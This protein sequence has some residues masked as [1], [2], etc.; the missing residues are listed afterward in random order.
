M[1]PILS[2]NNNK[3][4]SKY[5]SS[6]KKCLEDKKKAKPLQNLMEYYEFVQKL[7]KLTS[8]PNKFSIKKSKMH[9]TMP[10]WAADKTG[11]Y[12]YNKLSSGET[13]KLKLGIAL[14]KE[15]SNYNLA[16]Y[17][18]DD[19]N[20]IV[21]AKDSNGSYYVVLDHEMTI[22]AEFGLFR[23]FNK[24]SDP[25]AQGVNT[26]FATV[27]PL[28]IK[29]AQAI[30]KNKSW[31]QPT[32]KFK[33]GFMEKS[34]IV[35]GDS[36]K[37]DINPVDANNYDSSKLNLSIYLSYVRINADNT[38]SG[39]GYGIGIVK[40][41]FVREIVN[42]PV[43]PNSSE[44][45]ALKPTVVFLETDIDNVS[46]DFY[47]VYQVSYLGNDKNMQ[48][49]SNTEDGKVVFEDRLSLFFDPTPS[50]FGVF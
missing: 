29:I 17:Q 34:V 24:T 21:R 46:S 48:M 7:Q 26:V 25:K 5:I 23:E 2:K 38:E 1:K 40:S 42:D 16:C 12:F 31:K 27:F 22:C 45:Y 8:F 3:L 41:N 47:G 32:V 13:R 10:Y 15:K 19:K 20:N 11:V 14:N 49:I 43:I 44:L 9:M 28:Q 18:L 37:S 30:L 35:D 6:L 36:S 50:G 39:N 33:G 4:S